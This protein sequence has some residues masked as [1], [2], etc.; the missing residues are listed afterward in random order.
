MR[1]SIN[2]YLRSG[3]FIL[4]CI[5]LALASAF[6]WYDKIDGSQWTTLCLALFGVD[7]LSNA[8]SEGVGAAKASPMRT[9]HDPE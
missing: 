8:V 9:G 6:L 1:W 5:G 7:R 2:E 4:M 3:F